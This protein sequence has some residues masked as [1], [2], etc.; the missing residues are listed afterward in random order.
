M[1][2]HKCPY[3]CLFSLVIISN[4][5]CIC[6]KQPESTY[7]K[8]SL[9][10]VCSKLRSRSNVIGTVLMVNFIEPRNPRHFLLGV[11]CCKI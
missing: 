6:L 9:Y 2:K 3:M 1:V 5:W 11:T 10:I 7:L 8:Q 4:M